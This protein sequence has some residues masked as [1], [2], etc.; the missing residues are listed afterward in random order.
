MAVLAFLAVA[1]DD[2]Q[3]VVDADGEADHH[4]EVHRPHRQ[5]RAAGAQVD[6]GET[7][8]DPGHGQQQRM[9]AAIAEPNATNNRITVGRPD[10]QLGAVQRRLVL[11]VEVVPHRPTRR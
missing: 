7:D 10:T 6:G 9:P 4:R 3:A 8:G 2:E 11:G 1:G 5:R